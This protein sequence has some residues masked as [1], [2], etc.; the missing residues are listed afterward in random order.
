MDGQSEAS[1]HGFVSFPL[2]S[3]V[4][5][6]PKYL[7]LTTFP[8]RGSG[9]LSRLF[10][11]LPPLRAPPFLLSCLDLTPTIASQRLP[12]SQLPT[13]LA[14]VDVALCASDRLRTPS[15]P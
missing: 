1:V 13:P 8:A 4:L 10:A 12:S 11:H 7:T 5:L 2:F 9:L 6:A 14:S 3:C 15:F